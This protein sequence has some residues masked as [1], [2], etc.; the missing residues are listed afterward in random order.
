MSIRKFS[1]DIKIAKKENYL[2]Y[3]YADIFERDSFYSLE[4]EK[5]EIK[6]IF[7]ENSGI[8]NSLQEKWQQT[9]LFE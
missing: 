3:L 2:T 4:F 9:K 5:D 8:P 7:F 6:I 1:T